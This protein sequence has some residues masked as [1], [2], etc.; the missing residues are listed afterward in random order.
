VKLRRVVGALLALTLMMGTMLTPGPASAETLG[1]NILDPTEAA[2]SPSGFLGN[3]F[4]GV[5]N[6][7]AT[8]YNGAANAGTDSSAHN[9]VVRT[10]DTIGYDFNFNL[11]GG[12][13]ANIVL[14]ATLIPAGAAKWINAG[15]LGCPGGATVSPDGSV[16]TCTYGALASGVQD[17]VASAQ[18]LATATANGQHIEVTATVS[19]GGNTVTRLGYT[20]STGV[21]AVVPDD[22]ITSVQKAQLV[23]ATNNIQHGT[24]AHIF[25]HNNTGINGYLVTYPILVREGDGTLGAAQL[26]NAPL[27][28]TF[29]FV[30]NVVVPA[31]TVIDACGINGDGTVTIAGDPWGIVNTPGGHTTTNSVINSGTI[32]CGAIAGGAVTVTVT[33]ADTSGATYPTLDTNNTQVEAKSWVVSGYVRLFVPDQAT[34]TNITDIYTPDANFTG[35]T[36]SNSACTL[37]DP[38]LQLCS[39]NS[40]PVYSPSLSG[41]A[42]KSIIMDVLGGVPHNFAG[43]ANA[44]GP[45]LN[46]SQEFV[47]AI[48]QSNPSDSTTT[49]LAN[50]QSAVSCDALD[51]SKETVWAFDGATGATDATHAVLIDASSTATI[52]AVEYGNA[53]TNCTDAYGTS[54]GWT[55]TIDMVTPANANYYTNIHN[56][57]VRYEIDAENPPTTPNQFLK[58]YVNQKTLATDNPGDIVA[59]CNSTK[60]DI[61]Y[62]GAVTGTFTSGN[63]GQGQIFFSTYNIAK[64]LRADISNTALFTVLGHPLPGVD[65]NQEFVGYLQIDGHLN[66]VV[67]HDTYACDL[68]DTS[69]YVV[70]DF[71]LTTNPGSPVTGPVTFLTGSRS[72][73]NGSPA[74]LTFSTPNVPALDVEYSTDP[75]TGS[76]NCQSGT[77]VTGEPSPAATITKIRIHWDLQIN[78]SVMMLVN[79]KANAGLIGFG[80]PGAQTIVNKMAASTLALPGSP[81]T[82]AA[83]AEVL[84]EVVKLTKAVTPGSLSVGGTVTYT[85][86]PVLYGPA[87]TSGTVT[88]V[89][90]LPAGVSYHAASAV[91]TNIPPGASTWNPAS[92]NATPGIVTDPVSGVQTLTFTI[93]TAGAA[94]GRFVALPSVQFQADTSIVLANGAI[95]NN[96]VINDVN[97]TSGTNHT[98]SATFNITGSGG[99]NVAKVV[100]LAPT[101]INTPIN[102][103]L[104]YSNQGAADLPWTD[105]IDVL[106]FNG[107]TLGT[108]YNGTNTFVSILASDALTFQ[109]TNQARNAINLDPNCA[110]NGGSHGT[111][112]AFGSPGAVCANFSNTTW[113]NG[114]GVPGGPATAADVTGIRILGGVLA[115]GTTVLHTIDVSTATAGNLPGDLYWNQYDLRTT[116]TL[117]AQA[118]ASTAVPIPATPFLSLVKSCIS[119]ANCITAPQSPEQVNPTVITP[120]VYQIQATNT[121]GHPLQTLIITDPIPNSGGGTPTFYMDFQVGSASTTYTGAFT[122]AMFTVSYSADPLVGNASFTYTPVSTGGGAPAG[123]DRNVTAVRWTMIGAN[124]LAAAGGANVGTVQFSAAIR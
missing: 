37:A 51:T 65:P 104:R 5:G 38:G 84:T 41:D 55:T 30:D 73:V 57:R 39:S 6:F 60:A 44:N 91:F 78:Q 96:A 61:F 17:L 25:N 48:T 111:S 105:F 11:L 58:F 70:A 62:S 92:G 101:G 113:Y 4:T 36:P 23:K 29:T 10:N 72:T 14:Q 18:M 22:I 80:A 99:L 47:A 124:T 120:I 33:G 123:Y 103:E 13:G 118:Q 114:L 2:A 40:L 67:Q 90:T 49:G 122:G 64:G 15:S 108:H 74:T 43:T 35:Q 69:K 110:T 75:V 31:G 109:Y 107:D 88:I 76:D 16:L 54:A 45:A 81:Q 116:N 42:S 20:Q 28:S 1:L 24:T 95:V 7:D 89:D 112:V 86:N 9:H 85:L 115:H 56:V 32:S 26:G 117:V 8:S 100:T 79:L 12:G 71:D 53:S 83:S 106:P 27:P 3:G 87:A 77:W 63:C 121:G 46:P 102:W 66:T 94:A 52:A 68:I 19:D 34:T 21:D 98:A 50:L 82:A 97:D 93:G 59:D 119:P